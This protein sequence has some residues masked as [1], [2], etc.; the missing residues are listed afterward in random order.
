MRFKI[1]LFII[2]SM[3]FYS[4]NC[5]GLPKAKIAAKVVTVNGEPVIG[6]YAFARFTTSG[7]KVVRGETDANG[8]FTATSE[9]IDHCG[10]TI[11]K[12]GYYVGGVRY[13][14]HNLTLKKHLWTKR[15][16]PWGKVETVILKDIRNPIP[17]YAKNTYRL[18]IHKLDELV[19][20][21]LKIGDWVIPYGKGVI[22][23]FLFV[24]KKNDKDAK[25]SSENWHISYKLTFSNEKDGIQEYYPDKQNNRSEYIWPYEAPE[26]DYLSSYKGFTSIKDGYVKK[27]FDKK[28]NFIFRVRTKLDKNGKIIDARY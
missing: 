2:F 8:I 13:N 12:E 21:D 28:R 10:I 25:L 3:L 26:T 19:G 14:E 11:E 15:W 22:K 23:D 16:E 18:D 1:L 5:F 24:F 20:Y 6:A 17:M 7:S 4:T 9:T 27:N